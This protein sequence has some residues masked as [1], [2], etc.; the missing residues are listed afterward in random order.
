MLGPP[1]Q[2]RPYWLASEGFFEDSIFEVF[3]FYIMPFATVEKSCVNDFLNLI[4]DEVYE[5][6]GNFCNWIEKTLNQIH[7]Y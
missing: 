6:N 1:E 3:R 5:K 2:F 7:I 4:G